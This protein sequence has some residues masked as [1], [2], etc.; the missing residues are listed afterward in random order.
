M[1]DRTVEEM[2]RK[3]NDNSIE[4]LPISSSKREDM[5][6][7]G[8]LK[9]TT[10]TLTLAITYQKRKGQRGATSTPLHDR[11]SAPKNYLLY[12]APNKGLQAISEK[13]IHS[14]SFKCSIFKFLIIT[15]QSLT[16][17]NDLS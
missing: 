1:T 6:A 9:V 13:T 14:S 15:Q 12:D 7:K 5:F 3:H 16:V 4:G 17:S 11:N 10:C 2:Q 8:R